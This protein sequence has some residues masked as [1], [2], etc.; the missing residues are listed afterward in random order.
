MQ[1]LVRGW[2]GAKGY[3]LNV[4][5][6]V[7]QWLAA[8]RHMVD[9]KHNKASKCLLVLCFTVQQRFVEG[10]CLEEQAKG[11]KRWF[12]SNPPLSLQALFQCLSFCLII[13]RRLRNAQSGLASLFGVQSIYFS[14]HRAYPCTAL[15]SMS[16]ACHIASD[17]GGA[18]RYLMQHHHREE[19]LT[20]CCVQMK[21]G[22]LCACGFWRAWRQAFGPHG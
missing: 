12:P 14:E 1:V 18:T 17:R 6:P 9:P 13:S 10:T 21:R 7:P 11:N 2:G 22:C 20:I 5:L 8:V 16:M 4:P 3:I 19:I 15:I